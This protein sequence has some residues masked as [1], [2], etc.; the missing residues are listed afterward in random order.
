MNKINN[1][2]IGA[3]PAGLAA[4]GRMRKANIDFTIFEKSQYVGE[5]WRNRYDRL[6][7]HTVKKWSHLPHLPFPENYPTYVARQQLVDYFEKYKTKFNIQPEFGKEVLKIRKSG[8]DWQIDLKNGENYLAE[9]IVIASGLSRVPNIPKWPGQEKFK[10]KISHAVFYK[11]PY[12]YN[13]KKVLVVGIG[14]TGAEIALD[15]SNHDIK[16]YIVSRSKITLVPR[17]L[18]GRPV[19]ETAKTLDKIPFGLGDWVGSQIRKIY[20][21]NFIEI[22]IEDIQR[23]SRSLLCGKQ[24]RHL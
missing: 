19:Q 17:D 20:F 13:N 3:G 24:A 14:N 6:H 21:G 4:A 16:T 15:L 5:S 7:L 18:N 9:N 2:I 12:P 11:N 10:G 22:W 23:T 8:N 1:L